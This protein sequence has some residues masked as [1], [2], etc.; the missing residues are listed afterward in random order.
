MTLARSRTFERRYPPE[1]DSGQTFRRPQRNAF[2]RPSAGLDKP[3]P[4]EGLLFL[5]KRKTSSTSITFPLKFFINV[6]LKPFL[7]FKTQK[8][9][10]SQQGSIGFYLFPH[11]KHTN[12]VS[13]HSLLLADFPPPVIR[14]NPTRL[15]DGVS[16]AVGPTS[17]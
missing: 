9:D 17:F 4:N 8:A 2:L 6:F 12:S 1:G 11:K 14:A 15:C 16:I 13:S 5:G 7:T 3:L 10:G